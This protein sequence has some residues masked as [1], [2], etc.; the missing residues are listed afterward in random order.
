[1]VTVEVPPGV[2]AGQM[3]QLSNPLDGSLVTVQIPQASHCCRQ[4]A[5]DSQL[6]LWN[7]TRQS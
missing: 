4:S 5:V 7:D 3:I 6:V 2:A 1:M